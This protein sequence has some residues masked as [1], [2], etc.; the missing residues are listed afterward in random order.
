MSLNT[1]TQPTSDQSA[2]STSAIP[3]DT[4][5]A[6][7]MTSS[8]TDRTRKIRTDKGLHARHVQEGRNHCACGR[9]AYRKK[10]AYWICERCL[11]IEARYY[12]PEMRFRKTGFRRG[13][14]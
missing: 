7:S 8:A 14:V 13:G 1:S 6:A 10:S 4:A 2:R 11:E 3:A 9:I 5:N 12:A